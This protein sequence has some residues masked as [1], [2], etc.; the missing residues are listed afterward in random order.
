M[1]AIYE[2]PWYNHEQTKEEALTAR[3]L[4]ADRNAVK[5]IPQVRNVG[6][7][8]VAKVK[9]I[10]IANIR[11]YNPRLFYKAVNVAAGRGVW[12][13]SLSI[14]RKDRLIFMG[15]RTVRKTRRYPQTEAQRNAYN[16][17]QREYR[18]R[19][20][21]KVRRW[22]Q[23]YILRKAARLAAERGA[24]LGGGDLDAGA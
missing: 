6:C 19:N 12:A 22:Q 11:Q 10:T 20:P 2:Q 14:R 23:D 13:C 21:D 17:Y 15:N 24:A 16:R 5:A 7:N 8:T 18:Q 9:Y 1:L 3:F 4:F